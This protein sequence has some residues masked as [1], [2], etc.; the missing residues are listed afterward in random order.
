MGQAKLFGTKLA[1]T[2]GVHV[3]LQ[4]GAAPLACSTPNV[5]ASGSFASA[6]QLASG[7]THASLSS[8]A[9]ALQTASLQ[10]TILLRGTLMDST[11]D[12]RKVPGFA[13]KKTSPT[14]QRTQAPGKDVAA[15][16]IAPTTQP[17]RDI[18][19]AEW[20]SSAKE[21]MLSNTVALLASSTGPVDDPGTGGPPALAIPDPSSGPADTL[22][23][24]AASDG[25]FPVIQGT[26]LCA[27]P[28]GTQEAAT[29]TVPPFT[30]NT[31]TPLKTA[32]D[33]ATPIN[34]GDASWSGEALRNP[35][36]ATAPWRDDTP[37]HLGSSASR[38]A[39]GTHAGTGRASASAAARKQE[40]TGHTGA[41]AAGKP[42]LLS[43]GPASVA[44]AAAPNLSKG[45]SPGS[46][47]AAFTVGASN[48][49]SSPSPLV[50]STRDSIKAAS[51]D[52][53]K[54]LEPARDGSDDQ[55]ASP[56]SA[57]KEPPLGT[58]PNDGSASLPAL[59]VESPRAVLPANAATSED[60]LHA[61]ALP[62]RAD[63]SPA[64]SRSTP[65]PASTVPSPEEASPLLA[66]A[67]LLQTAHGSQMHV[68]LESEEFGRIT[69]HAGYGR[70]NLSA[71]IS[72]DHD[73]LGS[74]IAS[75]MTGVAQKLAGDSGLATSV[76]IT[77]T[78]TAA[79]S[80]DSGS[81]ANR[82][83]DGGSS[84]KPL[85]RDSFPAT[86]SIYGAAPMGETPHASVLLTASSARQHLDVTI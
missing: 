82:E 76:R 5:R 61:P 12:G 70:N 60:S 54:I 43:R 59:P 32:E 45:G 14:V 63:L 72:L 79:G 23:G 41:E 75:R 38:Y 78:G 17:L 8:T 57:A 37:F 30:P 68:Q 85:Q 47:P 84:R 25:T 19:Q 18:S 52:L 81:S 51:D 34:G 2:V 74:A 15:L 67:R 10:P 80:A 42:A 69:V 36:N 49:A 13:V 16:T 7:E 11:A 35:A 24:D 39:V 26:G 9:P 33:P 40:D 3:S 65:S 62:P 22:P 66:R 48:P 1:S 21:R 46:I 29:A 77:T 44:P 64:P 73:Q 83:R 6:V 55:E 58:D 86:P 28:S 53:A 50:R 20:V 71:Q 31:G 56:P 27:N 4:N